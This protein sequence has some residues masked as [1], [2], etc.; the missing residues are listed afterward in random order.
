M[1]TI[2][3]GVSPL[4]TSRLAYGC[5]RLAGTWN[6]SEVTPEGEAA[7][8]R[9]VIS[10]YEAGYTLFDHADVYCRG[11]AERIFGEVLKQVPGMR[12]RIVI[13]TK[14]GVR[15]ADDPAPGA[16][17]RYDFSAAHII[18]SCEKSLKRLGVE[19]IDLYQLHR[20]DYLAGPDE[21]AGAFTELKKSGKVRYFGVS[22]FRPTLVTAVQA[23]CPMPLIVNQ[24]EISLGRLNAFEDGTLDQCLIENLTPLAWSPL[25]RGLLGDGPRSIRPEQAAAYTVQGVLTALDNIARA[26]GTTRTVVALAW[27]LKHPAKIVPIVGSTNPDR[28]REAVKAADLDLTREEWY[29][30]LIAARGEPLP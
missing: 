17:S 7:G 11:V 27:L 21:I 13:A 5:W 19:T 15:F 20:P 12:D 18:S 23:A 28:I 4:L 29:Q 24:V 9:A 10:A 16:P 30:L 8:R 3:I 6:P 1:Q 22:N 25:A 14:C 2:P 26:R